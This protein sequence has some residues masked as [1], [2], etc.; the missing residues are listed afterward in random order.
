MAIGPSLLSDRLRPNERLGTGIMLVLWISS[1]SYSGDSLKSNQS[2]GRFTKKKT[3]ISKIL[4]HPCLCSRF[5]TFVD[6]A[7]NFCPPFWMYY[8][9]FDKLRHFSNLDRKRYICVFKHVSMLK[10]LSWYAISIKQFFRSPVE[11]RQLKNSKT[12]T[13]DS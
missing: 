13:V 10:M 4:V 6:K 2:R 9:V 5:F 12:Y 7:V 11:K 1:F 8:N 3:L